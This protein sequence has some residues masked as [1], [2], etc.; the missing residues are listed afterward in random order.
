MTEGTADAADD[1]AAEFQ[2][3]GVLASQENARAVVSWQGKKVA[4][5]RHGG[6]LY[7]FEDTCPHQGASLAEGHVEGGY[8]H[9]PWHG[10]RFEIATGKCRES[11]YGTLD[12]WEA[13]T[14]GER[15]FLRT[16]GSGS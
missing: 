7:A 5:V 9:C 6:S 11:A 2:E 10:W 4:V 13:R 14:E 8:V 1:S 16:R 3:V 15:L 12:L